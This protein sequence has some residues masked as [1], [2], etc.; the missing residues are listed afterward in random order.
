MRMRRERDGFLISNS[1]FIIPILMAGLGRTLVLTSDRD[2][3]APL[4]ERLSERLRV[5]SG[6][7]QESIS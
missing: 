7:R 4:S 3:S 1:T 5:R 6:D 2:V